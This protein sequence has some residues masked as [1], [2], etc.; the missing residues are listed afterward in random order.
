MT[1]PRLNAAKLVFKT[2]GHTGFG[3]MTERRETKQGGN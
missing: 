1:S 3:E 2:A